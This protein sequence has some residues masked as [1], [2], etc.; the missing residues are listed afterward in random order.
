MNIPIFMKQVRYV[1]LFILHKEINNTEYE[2]LLQQGQ[3]AL[4]F[5]QIIFD[6]NQVKFN[7]SSRIT[8]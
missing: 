1:N 2:G 4:G 8:E 5:K 3:Q 7:I 6:R